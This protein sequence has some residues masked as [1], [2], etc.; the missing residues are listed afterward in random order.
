MPSGFVQSGQ[1]VG[2]WFVSTL[3][4]GT[5]GHSVAV[6][7]EPGLPIDANA[8]AS[9]INAVLND[10][11]GWPSKGFTF[12]LVSNPMAANIRIHIASPS[13]TD[14]KCYPMDT[15]GYVSCTWGSGDIY[16]NSDRWEM[17]V[18]HFKSLDTYR[19]YL[20]SHETGHALGYGHVPCPG[21]GKP[22]PVMMQQTYGLDGCT[23]NGWVSVA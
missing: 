12:R 20:I 4:Q 7:V 23:E 14:A 6:L 15:D 1:R 18:P 10:P 17:G 3:N 22:A 2:D 13:T 9:L 11:R 21:A 16:L 19:E 8:A 5:G